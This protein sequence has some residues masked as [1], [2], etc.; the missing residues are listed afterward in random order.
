MKLADLAQPADVVK[1]VNIEKM[2]NLKKLVNLVLLVI[3]CGNGYKYLRLF[4]LE[5]KVF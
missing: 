4:F 5:R 3:T 1:I 2:V